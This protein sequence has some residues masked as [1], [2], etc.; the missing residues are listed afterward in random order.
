MTIWY[1]QGVL[2]DLQPV[3]RKGLGRVGKLFKSAGQDLFVTSLRDGNHS[4]GS[5]H[6]SGLAFDCRKPT[7]I[8]TLSLKFIKDVLGSNWDVVEEPT[9]I[10]CEYDP[11]DR[12]II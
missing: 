12:K 1:K 10:H 11:K 8:E 3:A 2:G 5:L 7:Y 4:Y 6:Y 9:H